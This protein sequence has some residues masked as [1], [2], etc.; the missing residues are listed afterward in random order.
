MNETK[1]LLAALDLPEGDLH[2]LPSSAKRFPDGAQYRIEIPT[3]EGPLVLQNVLTEAKARQVPVHR[4]S[5]GSGIMLLT[6]DE[7]LDM[8]RIGAEESIEVSLFTGP[9]ATYDIHAQPLTPSGKSVGLRAAGMD[10]VVYALEDVHRACELNIRSVLVA[11]EGV[12][13]AIDRFKQT[14][15]LP[16]DL[17]VKVS[18]SMGACNPVSIRL[19]ESIGASTY[20]VPTDLNLARLAAIR[21]AIDIPIDIYVEVPDDF[22]GFIRYYEIC[23]IIRVAAPVY[24][25]FGLRNAQNMYP[26]GTHLEEAAV[27]LAKE[28]VR[29][30]KIGYDM[31]RRYHPEYKTSALGAPGIG[32]PAEGRKPVG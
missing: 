8:A 7:I 21:H 2:H 3:V 16:A 29:R 4:V 10:Q 14:G 13:W 11:D 27:K 6:D 5:Q 30:A 31:I 9:R 24:I 28:R 22:G 17:V 26:S 15:R 19:L 23:E 25:K 1:K 12:L 32:V 18:V 20:N